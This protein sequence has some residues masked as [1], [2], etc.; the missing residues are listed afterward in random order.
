MA[1]TNLWTPKEYSEY[2][3]C[4]LRK[5]DR[6]RAEGRGPPYVRIDGRIFYR[7][8]DVEEFIAAHLCGRD[9]A[10]PAVAAVVSPRRRAA[11]RKAS[12]PQE[13]VRDDS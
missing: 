12:M 5:A 7:R 1:E 8:A 2:R 9:R 3:R 11:P 4:S 6:E 10:F 13:N